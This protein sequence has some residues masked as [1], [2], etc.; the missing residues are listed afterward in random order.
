MNP[1]AAIYDKTG[2]YHV[3]IRTCMYK[4]HVMYVYLV[5]GS[6]QREIFVLIR[7]RRL[8]RSR[9]F[10]SSG[11]KTGIIFSINTRS[12]SYPFEPLLF[13]QK[14]GLKEKHYK[15][16]VNVVNYTTEKLRLAADCRAAP[17]D[18]YIYTHIIYIYTYCAHTYIYIL[19]IFKCI[20][21]Y[22]S[23]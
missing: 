12:V 2:L 20:C 14:R 13:Q 9:K 4:N 19:Y 18:I 6:S 17:M 23:V 16:I 22:M 7:G 10:N 11:P 15:Y 5:Q 3:C 8:S 21:I 1:F